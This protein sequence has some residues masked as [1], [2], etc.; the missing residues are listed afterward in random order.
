[1]DETNI[2]IAETQVEEQATETAEQ[3]AK[4]YTQSEV[5]D[6]LKGY[7]STD[8]VEQ[9]VKAR[10]AREKAAQE[11]AVEEAKRLEKMNAEEKTQYELNKLREENEELKKAQSYTAMSKEASVMLSE[12]GITANDELLAMVVKD[13]AEGTKA[14]VGAFVEI[15]NKM[16]EAQVKEKLSGEPPKAAQRTSKPDSHETR[17]AEAVKSGD[18][19]KAIQ[20]KQEAYKEGIILN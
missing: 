8:E 14:A 17:Y 20:I 1:M 9:I 10:V 7:K 18:T 3:A 11:K 16:V 4:T 6:M 12:Q 15:V 13:D 2:D 5:D 19:L